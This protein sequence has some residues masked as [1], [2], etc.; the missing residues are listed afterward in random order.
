MQKN[1]DS[2]LRVLDPKDNSTGGGTA[3]A[4][5][6]AMAAALAAMVA[7]ISMGREGMEPESYYQTIAD[8]GEVLSRSLFNRGRED[9]EAFDMVMAAFKMPKSSEEEKAAR[10]EAIARAMLHA[11]EVP[12][13]NA[14][15]CRRVLEL[16]EKLLGRSNTNAASDLESAGHLAKAGLLGCL[17]NVAINLPSVKDAARS[18]E[19]KDRYEELHRLATSSDGD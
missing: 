10:K 15:D 17:A 16:C 13:A 3:S 6:G 8:E 11:T 19:I 4:V 18:R 1:I 7:R 9:S 14:E 12:L 2:F 5:A